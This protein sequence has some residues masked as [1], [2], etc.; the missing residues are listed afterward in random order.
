VLVLLLDKNMTCS[1]SAAVTH[2]TVACH[3]RA[4]TV[5]LLCAARQ[6]CVAQRRMHAAVQ[7]DCSAPRVGG[8]FKVPVLLLPIHMC[9]AAIAAA[10]TLLECAVEY[11][12]LM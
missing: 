11:M 8:W 10:A 2:H 1:C 12:I 5:Q 4:N 7:R 9:W 6:S 3:R